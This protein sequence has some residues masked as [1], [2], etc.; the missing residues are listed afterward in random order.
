MITNY[1]TNLAVGYYQ[2]VIQGQLDLEGICGKGLMIIV[3]FFFVFF[4]YKNGAHE[5]VKQELHHSPNGQRGSQ[6]FSGFV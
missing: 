5:G 6:I 3:F 1:N 2:V 4:F